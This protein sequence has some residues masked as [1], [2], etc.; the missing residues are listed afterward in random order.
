MSGHIDS[1]DEDCSFCDVRRLLPGGMKDRD[2]ERERARGRVCA[3][4]FI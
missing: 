1:S 4:I 2:R 3:V